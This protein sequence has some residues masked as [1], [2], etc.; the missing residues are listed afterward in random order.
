MGKVHLFYEIVHIDIRCCWQTTSLR[1]ASICRFHLVAIVVARRSPL[2]RRVCVS[3]C[4]CASVMMGHIA[5]MFAPHRHKVRLVVV[6]TVG[7]GGRGGED[8]YD[9]G[10]W[11]YGFVSV[12]RERAHTIT[13]SLINST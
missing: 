10:E 8:G 7:D 6:D 13:L 11:L 3:V 12:V 9:D 5:F 1:R 2:C 4:L